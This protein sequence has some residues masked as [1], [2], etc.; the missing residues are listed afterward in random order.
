MTLALINRDSLAWQQKL[1]PV[2]Q[3]MEKSLAKLI[4][5]PYRARK[6]S[7]HLPDFIDIV[8]N[9]GDDRDAF[10]ATIGQ[11]LPNWGK[12]ANDNRGRTVA[13]TN[14][15]EDPDSK[16]IR[17]EQAASLLTDAT[18]KELSS[19]PTPALLGTILHEATHNLGPAHE[20][21]VRG[22][23]DDDVFGGPLAQMLE[24]LKAQTGALYFLGLL[25]E[26]GVIDEKLERRVLR[27]LH[28]LGFRA[29]LPRDVD[30]VRAAQDL[31]PAGCH[32]AWLPDGRR[33]RDL[34]RQRAGCQ[35]PRQRRLHAEAG[36]V[37]SAVE[38]LM[39]DVGRIKA[40]GDKKAALAS[41]RSTWMGKS[42]PSS[43]SRS[44]SSEPEDQ[45]RLLCRSLS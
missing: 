36:G 27:G 44:A 19:D 6:V 21:K 34:R 14:L 11:S 25:A 23:T 33:R 17:R 8:V 39:R 26:K 29:H 43:S 13:M 20:Y 1:K 45:L 41:A 30:R 37:P 10:G 31:Q 32:P 40:R 16:R 28:R 12:V 9:A 15:F 42:F 3:D 7:F 35:R 5:G 2:Q 38:K 22:K 18:Q 4:G 24:E